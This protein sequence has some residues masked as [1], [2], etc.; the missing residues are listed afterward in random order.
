MG[1]KPYAKSKKT[2]NRRAW[3]V[4]A[5]AFV[6]GTARTTGSMDRTSWEVEE[7]R[8]YGAGSRLVE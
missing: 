8:R 3:V 4:E 2:E 6:A 7:A 1:V 5:V